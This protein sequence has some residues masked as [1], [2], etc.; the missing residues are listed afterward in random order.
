MNPQEL[1]RKKRDGARFS[2]EEIG[3]FIAGVSDGSWADYQ[4]T[5]L[6]MA[7]FI[8]GLNQ[9]EQN[10]LVRS[11]LGSGEVLDFADI[12]APKADK[13]STGGVGDKT[14]LVI[15]PLAAA[16]GVAVPMIS[17][18]GLGHTG[19]DGAVGFGGR[20]GSHPAESTYRRTF[21]TVR[22]LRVV[23]DDL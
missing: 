23:V 5:A 11:M 15:A 4:I 21:S 3:A 1:I 9:A 18:R 16:C 8:H 6:V 13:H 2:D 10:A 20:F 19:Q 14:S 7:M 22:R 17:G 12:D